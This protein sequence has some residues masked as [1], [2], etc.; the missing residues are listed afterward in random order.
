MT[1]ASPGAGAVFYHGPEKDLGM[2]A[3]WY[4]K[5]PEAGYETAEE[6]LERIRIVLGGEYQYGTANNQ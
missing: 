1:P 4:R 6:D 3:E 5:A 2:A